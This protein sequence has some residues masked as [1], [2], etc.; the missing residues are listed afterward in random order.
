LFIP[1]LDKLLYPFLG[2]YTP[3]M[4]NRI[5]IGSVLCV[6]VAAV[7]TALFYSTGLQTGFPLAHSHPDDF[8]YGWY[9]P[10][11][12]VISALVLGLSEIMIEVGGMYIH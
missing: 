3:N 5:A 6:L 11:I 4:K 9:V 2:G 1:I 7:L 12:A 8:S 10:F